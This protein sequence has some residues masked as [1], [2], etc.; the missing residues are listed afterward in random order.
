MLPELDALE[1]QGLFSKTELRSIV[2]R[3]EAFEYALQRRAARRLDYERYAAYEESLEALRS[4]R[5]RLFKRGDRDRHRRGKKEKR[6]KGSDKEEE[7]ERL[8]RQR[9]ERCFVRR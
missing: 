4:A 6:G 8:L 2:A 5:A 9:T 7:R 1:E 3:R